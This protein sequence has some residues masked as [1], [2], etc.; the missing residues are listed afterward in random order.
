MKNIYCSVFGHKYAISKKITHHVKEYK[1]KNCSAQL[2]TNSKGSLIPLTPKYKE[3]NSVLEH[4]HNK[5]LQKKQSE[6]LIFDHH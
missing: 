2:T 4:I 3:I 6:R 5:R 1:C